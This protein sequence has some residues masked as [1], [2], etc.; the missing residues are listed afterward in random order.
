MQKLRD[1][2]PGSAEKKNSGGAL[3]KEKLADGYEF[4]QDR[5]LQAPRELLHETGQ[6]IIEA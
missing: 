3:F 1:A 4:A 5:L 2:F 6:P